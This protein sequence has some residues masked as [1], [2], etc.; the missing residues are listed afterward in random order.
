[1]S[2]H[3]RFM[4]NL[5]RFAGEPRVR[6]KTKH[7]GTPHEESTEVKQWWCPSCRKPKA[8]Q[9]EHPYWL[10]YPKPRCANCSDVEV[11][12]VLELQE[13]AFRG[14]SPPLVMCHIVQS[15]RKK[16]GH[17]PAIGTANGEWRGACR[18]CA[19]CRDFAKQRQAHQLSVTWAGKLADLAEQ[20]HPPRVWRLQIPEADKRRVIDALTYRIERGG[21][22]IAHIPIEAGRVIFTT[23]GRPSHGRVIPLTQLLVREGEYFMERLREPEEFRFGSTVRISLEEQLERRL[24]DTFLSRVWEIEGHAVRISFKQRQVS[25]ENHNGAPT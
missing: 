14:D 6:H 7:S 11:Y 5:N 9:L 18:R 24:F 12:E 17:W 25:A 4:K 8:L 10:P 1:M 15:Y 23:F 3:D 22:A 21:G 2:D 19:G 16:T 13:L 20:L